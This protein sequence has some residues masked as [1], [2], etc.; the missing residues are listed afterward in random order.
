VSAT[1]ATPREPGRGP[2]VYG[3]LGRWGIGATVF[4]A[5]FLLI[6]AGGSLAASPR[7]ASTGVALAIYQ[8]NNV[9]EE[10]SFTVSLEVASTANIHFVY[11]TF[12]QLSSPLCYLPVEMTAH[13]SNWFVG[14]TNPMTSYN[15]M[16]PGVRAGYNI[17]VE[18][19]NGTNV[20]EPT[21]PN[22]FSNLTI[23]QSV[24]GEYM[25]QMTVNGP[26]YELSGVVTNSATGAGMA[27][28]TV[29][30]TPENLTAT[31]TGATGAYSI[32]GLPNGTYNISVT[33]PGFETAHGTV[34]IAG[35]DAVRNLVL[36]TNP[37]GTGGA[38]SWTVPGIGAVSPL[39]LL[40]PV[41]LVIAGVAIVLLARKPRSG[42]PPPAPNREP[43]APSDPKS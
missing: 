28:A 8:S 27:G 6:G 25:F 36:S 37:S 16:T 31:T 2:G 34:T 26:V 22:P 29:L 3:A 7:P 42:S 13:G 23:A 24:T 39:V 43:T 11:F 41:V 40:V 9:S 35:S 12:C 21:V 33:D 10:G 17:T 20:T 30:V 32:P 18:Y 1:A 5:L 15:G 4:V 14:T 19:S 38:D